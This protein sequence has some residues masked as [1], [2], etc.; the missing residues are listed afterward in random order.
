MP[1]VVD[2]G[3][4][5]VGAAVLGAGGHRPLLAPGDDVGIVAAGLRQVV[6]VVGQRAAH[7][8]ADGEGGQVLVGGAVA[9][10]GRHIVLQVRAQVLA[11]EVVGD[12]G[13]RVAVAAAAV[14]AGA[15]P[16][17]R[18]ECTVLLADQAAVVQL[19]RAVVAVLVAG[20]GRNADVPVAV[21]RQQCVVALAGV[22]HRVG[23]LARIGLAEVAADLGQRPAQRGVAIDRL[24]AVEQPIEVAA[25]QAAAHAA[26]V[27][28]VGD[29]E[30]A[31]AGDGVIAQQR[32]ADTVVLADAA[33]GPAHRAAHRQLAAAVVGVPVGVLLAQRHRGGAGVGGIQRDFPEAPGSFC[34]CP[35]LHALPVKGRVCSN[36]PPAL[37]RP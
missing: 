29:I 12:I 11:P 6:A 22:L 30:E 37:V 8:Q 32:D 27:D 2:V 20:F 9:L 4:V 36:F 19:E 3:G 10:G 17:G 31:A 16:V 26:A 25:L 18:V 7:A 33:E 28:E 23:A 15:V 24:G 5:A 34:C 35:C 13:Q 14:A 21:G 1:Q